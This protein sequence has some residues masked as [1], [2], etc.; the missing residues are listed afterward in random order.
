MLQHAVLSRFTMPL[1]TCS[2]ICWVTLTA[3]GWGMLQHAIQSPC[4]G[5]LS[6]CSCIYRVTLAA[7]GWGMLNMWSSHPVEGVC[8]RAVAYTGWPS[9]HL[10]GAC[11][12]MQSSHP[13]EGVCQRAVAYTGWPSQCLAGACYYNIQF[14]HPNQVPLPNPYWD[15][16]CAVSSVWTDRCIKVDSFILPFPVKTKLSAAWTAPLH[17]VCNSSREPTSWSQWTHQHGL[18]SSAF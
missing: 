15:N 9:Q 8:Q 6:T 17:C 11:Y 16:D 10:A 1:S 3:F 4:G 18:V 14:H 13:V 12:N 7:F 5:C 2:C